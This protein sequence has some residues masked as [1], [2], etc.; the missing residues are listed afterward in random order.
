MIRWLLLLSWLAGPASA[1]G[2]ASTDGARAAGRI[3]VDSEVLFE[4]RDALMFRDRFVQMLAIS[5]R[6]FDMATM[7]ADK[8][9]D[10]ADLQRH[11]AS[12]A[13]VVRIGLGGFHRFPTVL[14]WWRGPDLAPLMVDGHALE[15]A[16]RLDSGDPYR[17]RGTVD[18]TLVDSASGPRPRL[19]LAFDVLSAEAFSSS[20]RWL[21]P[22]GGAPGAALQAALARP[23]D[24][25]DRAWK[26]WLHP[27]LLQRFAAANGL[28]EA[29]SAALDNLLRRW[30]PALA[31]SGLRGALQPDQAN[32]DLTTVNGQHWSARL[33]PVTPKGPD[34]Q[35]TDLRRVP[36][37]PVHD[38]LKPRVDDLA[39]VRQTSNEALEKRRGEFWLALSPVAMLFLWLVWRFWRFRQRTRHLEQHG[40]VIEA[41]VLD[42]ERLMWGQHK[43][44]MVRLVLG[45]TDAHSG[46]RL[47]VRSPALALPRR[48]LGDSADAQFAL[49]QQR[50]RAPGLKV[51]LRVDPDQPTRRFD[52]NGRMEIEQLIGVR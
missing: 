42:L 30:L 36:V 29:D 28:Q 16:L 22:G 32:F 39:K 1:Q 43:R 25:A 45:W 48:S 38:S 18:L 33:R 49:W 4:A 37:L 2:P 19:S 20:D 7:L 46:R 21:P 15:P 44:V 10:H 9:L 8:Q 40:E 5:D 23:A 52:L 12:G 24:P 50:A 47:Q 34:W 11:H 13:Q 6:P 14:T 26:Q 35:V 3:T 51:R 27:D 41:E 31:E 17:F